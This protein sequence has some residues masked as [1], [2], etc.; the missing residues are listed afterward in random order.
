MQFDFVND[1]VVNLSNAETLAVGA[2][3]AVS[4]Q[5]PGN[6]FLIVTTVDT[7]VA[8]GD[9]PST[10]SG[11]GL[12]PAGGRMV[13]SAAAGQK[14]AVKAVGAGTGSATLYFL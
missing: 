6:G 10:G 7:W 4:D 12:V 2:S 8:I 3:D 9:N 5:I 1:T 11:Q 13:F 14:V